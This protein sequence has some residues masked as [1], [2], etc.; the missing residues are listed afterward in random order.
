MCKK[1]KKE[2]KKFFAIIGPALAGPD[3][4]VPAPLALLLLVYTSTFYLVIFARFTK[5]S[6]ESLMY[7][8]ICGHVRTIISRSF[9]ATD[10]ERSGLSKVI[11]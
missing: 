9:P 7:E 4:A 8:T 5:S 11:F 1:K 3:G 6:G 10:L 2:K